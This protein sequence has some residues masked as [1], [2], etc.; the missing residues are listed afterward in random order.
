[1]LSSDPEYRAALVLLSSKATLQASD[2]P[3]SSEWHAP[4]APGPARQVLGARDSERRTL[5]L[6]ALRCAYGPCCLASVR[7]ARERQGSWARRCLRSAAGTAAFSIAR[8]RMS[9][10]VGSCRHRHRRYERLRVFHWE[11]GCAG[12]RR[13]AGQAGPCRHPA[14][15]PLA[16]SCHVC[17]Q[18]GCYLEI[19]VCIGD[20]GMPQIG[21]E[22]RDMPRHGFGIVRTGLK[23]ANSKC[24]GADHESL[25]PVFLP[26]RASRLTA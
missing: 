19:P 26:H 17:H 15:Q 16:V 22:G 6:P 11:D 14:M 12:R 23:G 5:R 3:S 18:L 20:M 25:G 7:C 13:G 21:T 4:E 9:P 24:V 1:M 2:Q 8:R 10:A